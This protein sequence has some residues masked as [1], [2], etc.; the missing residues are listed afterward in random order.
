VTPSVAAPGDTNLTDATDFNHEAAT[1][2]HTHQ[3]SAKLEDRR[4]IFFLDLTRN[5]SF[6]QYAAPKTQFLLTLAVL[7]VMC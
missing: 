1:H 6:G 5:L 3:I 2:I 7:L 4:P